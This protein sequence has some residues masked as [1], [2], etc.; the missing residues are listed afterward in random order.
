M[1]EMVDELGIE[2]PV[3]RDAEDRFTM[4]FDGFV[5][6]M[7]VLIDRAGSVVHV[8][9]GRNPHPNAG[10][11]EAG[12]PSAAVSAPMGHGGLRRY[13]FRWRPIRPRG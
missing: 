1:T 13:G 2:M 9:H 6:P 5:V 7:S 10:G 4:V 12:R 8:W 3:W 11:D